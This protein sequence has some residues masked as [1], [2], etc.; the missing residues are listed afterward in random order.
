MTADIIIAT[1]STAAIPPVDGLGSV[2]VW[3][4]TGKPPP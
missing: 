4:K 1:G 2:P 3:T